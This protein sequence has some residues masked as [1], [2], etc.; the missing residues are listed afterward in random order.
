MSSLAGKA[1]R[2]IWVLAYFLAS[3]A[4]LIPAPLIEFRY[5]TIPFFLLVLHSP[6]DD[7]G[8]W[9]LM[10]IVYLAVNAFTMTMFLYRPFHWEHE[11]GIQRFIW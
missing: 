5:Y 11:P 2:K 9:L 10:G 1:Q 6:T 3:A 8:S 4:A 7:A